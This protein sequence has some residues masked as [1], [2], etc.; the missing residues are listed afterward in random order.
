MANEDLS[1]ARRFRIIS[2]ISEGYQC[3]L[4][5][6]GRERLNNPRNCS[7]PVGKN[8]VEVL[9]SGDFCAVPN[10]R[11]VVMA[12]THGFGGWK[13]ASIPIKP[14][15]PQFSRLRLTWRT[16]WWWSSRVRLMSY[17]QNP[18]WWRISGGTK[19]PNAG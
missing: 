18:P 13:C 8:T 19:G 2:E 10:S 5:Q 1:R 16:Q 6:A 3:P 11:L 7:Q 12:S 17:C 15:F 9:V 14:Q 4:R